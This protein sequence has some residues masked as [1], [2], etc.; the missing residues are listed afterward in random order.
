MADTGRVTGGQG[1]WDRRR[2]A[3]ALAGLSGL[4]ALALLPLARGAL[5][6]V[7]RRATA[8]GDPFALGAASG[9]P[10]PAMGSPRTE[11][12]EAGRYPQPDGFVLRTRLAPDPLAP[13]GA[14]GMPP[15]PVPVEWRVATDERMRNVVRRGTVAAL[16]ELV[17]A[18]HAVHVEPAGLRPGRTYWYQFRF[19][20]ETSPVGRTRT[21][22][23]RGDRPGRL[24]FAFASCQDDGGPGARQV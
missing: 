8:G 15:R 22:P 2:F 4:A 5:A 10:P 21:T 20:G 24:S 6:D 9:A 7:P 1:G 13:G 3:G 14:G 23:A 11:S 19:A 18:V 12:G 17:H 16:P